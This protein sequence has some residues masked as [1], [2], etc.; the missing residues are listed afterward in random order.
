MSSPATG[1]V[2]TAAGLTA[3]LVE[4]LARLLV[5]NT[6]TVHQTLRLCG[7]KVRMGYG[8]WQTLL[9]TGNR[10]SCVMFLSQTACHRGWCPLT[11]NRCQR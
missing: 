4:G 3:L 7:Q 6:V 8:G 5:K 11:I 9:P 1:L 2:A 10:T